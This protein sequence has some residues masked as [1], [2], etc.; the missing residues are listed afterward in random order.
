MC[1]SGLVHD[2]VTLV[3]RKCIEDLGVFLGGLGCTVQNSNLSFKMSMARDSTEDVFPTS[4][5]CLA[6]AAKTVAAYPSMMCEF[7]ELNLQF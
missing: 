5:H 6:F 4:E 1:Q 3:C 7:E 2:N